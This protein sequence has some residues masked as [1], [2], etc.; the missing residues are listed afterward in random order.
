MNVILII[1]L[2]AV[3]VGLATHLVEWFGCLVAYIRKDPY[4]NVDFS[5]PISILK[6]VRGLNTGD[7]E[8][9][10]SFFTLD[11]PEYEILFLIH[12][13]AGDDPAVPA[14]EKLMG[15]YPDVRASIVRTSE[16]VAVHEKVNNYIEGIE[17]ARYDTICITDADCYVDRD[18]LKRDVRPL[19]DPQVGMV[20]ALQTMNRF[21]SIPTAFEGVMQNFDGSMFWLASHAFR[22]LDFVYGHSLFLR[23]SDFERLNVVDE[24]KDHMIDDQAWGIAYVHKGGM[25]IWLSRRPAHTRYPSSTW[26]KVGS[27]IVRWARFQRNYAPVIYVFSVVHYL[28]LWGAL[29]IGLSFAA[30]A[31]AS[32]FGIPLGLAALYG[33]IAAL[34]VRWISVIAGNLLFA[35]DPKDLRYIWTLLLRDPFTAYAAVKSYFVNTFEHAGRVYRL[36]GNRMRRVDQQQ[37][38]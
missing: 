37:S 22:G 30:P 32:V 24:V 11:Y 27:H 13:D 10:R 25:R 4:R 36:E 38:S 15:E 8:N 34:G 26:K 18:Y 20:T 21:E 14:I 16:T 6:P 17:R 12:R 7:E 28:T 31:G 35:D 1:V 2:V 3:L 23:K 29:A 33:G 19:S 5:P 9:F